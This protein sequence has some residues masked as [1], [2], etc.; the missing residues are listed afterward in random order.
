MKL[1]LS[2]S[3]NEYITAKL[4]SQCDIP[5]AMLDVLPVS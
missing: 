4:Y 3:V 2:V 1:S 5:D